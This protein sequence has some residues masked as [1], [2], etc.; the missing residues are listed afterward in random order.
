MT[1]LHVIVPSAFTDDTLPRI[2]PTI[3]G[4]WTRRW[5]VPQGATG[6]INELPDLLGGAPLAMLGNPGATKQMA[7]TQ[8]SH[9]R[10]YATFDNAA[11]SPTVTY[12]NGALGSTPAAATALIFG[13]V[14][15]GVDKA[16]YL[17]ALAGRNIARQTS[18]RNMQI[19]WAPY[20]PSSGPIPTG[21]SAFGFR[22]SSAES[23]MW[24]NKTKTTLATA[25]PPTGSTI[26]IN[27]STENNQD[28][29]LYEVLYADAALT[30]A[31]IGAAVDALNAWYGVS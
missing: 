5:A 1:G 14:P 13:R 6:V 11:K 25:A 23:S 21:P 31:Q 10:K 16:L 9:G 17:L 27:G 29:G 7:I 26:Q 3:P 12:L 2:V 22:S 8:D 28:W 24:I 30:D 19:A 18:G 20:T 15:A 4:P